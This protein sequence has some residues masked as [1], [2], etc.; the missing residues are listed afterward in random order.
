MFHRRSRKVSPDPSERKIASPSDILAT[1]ELVD[2]QAHLN[3]P[4][5]L[6]SHLMPQEP[7]LEPESRPESSDKA[8]CPSII[9]NAPIHCPLIP[10][11]KED[12]AV[13]SPT[14]FHFKDFIVGSHPILISS[15]SPTLEK[16]VPMSSKGK[17]PVVAATPY[18]F[19]ISSP[20]NTYDS[21]L[22]FLLSRKSLKLEP[23]TIHKPNN[24]ASPFISPNSVR[25]ITIR[26][27][28]NGGSRHF[29]GRTIVTNSGVRNLS[30]VDVPIYDMT[31]TQPLRASMAGASSK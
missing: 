12:I 6:S 2:G 4:P 16:S 28:H 18:N 8:S 3:P 10:E 25:N 23:L 20:V 27:K 22:D 5:T 26:K 13:P 17:E 14:T 19:P 7:S 9:K 11:P 31:A 1:T 29:R 24:P 30:L 15:S 21:D